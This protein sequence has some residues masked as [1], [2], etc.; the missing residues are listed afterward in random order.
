MLQ[1]NEM[2]STEMKFRRR[3]NE[4]QQPAGEVVADD[5]SATW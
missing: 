4:C 2:N 5:G 1:I 3:S